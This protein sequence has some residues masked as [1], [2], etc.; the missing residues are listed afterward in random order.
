MRNVILL[1]CVLFASA[2]DVVAPE[3]ATTVRIVSV[4]HQTAKNAPAQLRLQNIGPA[5]RFHARAYEYNST[6]SSDPRIVYTDEVCSR[7]PAAIDANTTIDTEIAGCGT[8]TL[9]W[10]VIETSVDG[11]NKWTRTACYEVR[12][13]SCTSSLERER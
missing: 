9:D 11:G 8:H 4:T 6:N 7:V 12:G 3:D 13:Y 2:C 10:I 5:G 1:G